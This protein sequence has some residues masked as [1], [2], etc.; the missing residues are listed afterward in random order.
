MKHVSAGTGPRPKTMKAGVKEKVIVEAA[1]PVAKSAGFRELGLVAPVILLLPV[2]LAAANSLWIFTDG[3]WIDAWVSFGYFQHLAAYKRTLFPDLYYG[4]R[5]PW[6]LPGYVAYHLFPP[7][8]ANYVLHFT[9]YYTAVF[10][11]YFLLRR[12]VGFWN[13]LLAAVLFGSY[14]HFLSS[15][16]RDYVD[17]AGSTYFLLALA[18]AARATESRLRQVWLLVSGMAGMAMCYTNLF[19]VS[20]VPFIPG[21]YLFM[22]FPGVNRKLFGVVRDVVV[23][24]GGGAAILS[25]A[26]GGIN[27]LVDRNIWFYS[28]SIY[29]FIAL[30]SRH[31]PWV[32]HGW[33]WLRNALWL[34]IPAAATLAS[35]AYVL[36]D[37]IRGKLKLRDFRTFFVLQFLAIMAGMVAWQAIGETGLYYSFYASYV[38]PAMFLAIGCVLAGAEQERPAPVWWALI[39]ATIAVMVWTLHVANLA[40]AY[41]VRTWASITTAAALAAAALIANVLLWK[42][43]YLAIAA[44]AGLAIYQLGY[45]R[46]EAPSPRYEREWRH[47]VEGARAIWPYEQNQRSVSFWYDVNAPHGEELYGINSVYLWGYTYVS[48]RFPEIDAPARLIPGA[49][50]VMIAAPGWVD[51]ANQALR[52]KH[53]HGTPT[54]TSTIGHDADSFEI[55]FLQLETDP[56]R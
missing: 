53:F 39:L 35:L 56:V 37:A 40:P 7:K 52:V 10:S 34:G 48:T 28:P 55:G 26:L 6:I 50:I 11:L 38:I 31:N 43:W 46:F 23:W 21:L 3:R 24:I 41:S 45:S 33:S 18:A 12:A 49:T 13:A 20:F 4:T 29:A 8:T 51:R 17:G 30:R 5:L 36:R 47:I 19:L 42:K 44:I 15:I 32:A 14:A 2:L 1:N 27:Y 22:M 25:V 9:F 54:G 16:G